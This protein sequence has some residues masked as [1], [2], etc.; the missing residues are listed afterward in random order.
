[1]DAIE[2]T[3][4]PFGKHI[5]YTRSRCPQCDHGF[6]GWRGYPDDAMRVLCMECGT[7]WVT[8]IYVDYGPWPIETEK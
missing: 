5:R 8:E 7:E 2:Q 3:I 1:M 4:P 6:V